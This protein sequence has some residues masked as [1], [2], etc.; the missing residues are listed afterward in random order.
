MIWR[1]AHAD[2]P[3]AQQLLFEVDWDRI[4]TDDVDSSWLNWQSKFL[5]IMEICIPKK[6]LSSKRRNLPWLTKRIVQAMRR[7]NALFKQ[8]MRNR[9]DS[10]YAKY[11]EAR[12]NVVSSL[13]SAK[14]GYFHKPSYSKKFW[15]AVKCLN[16]NCS[17]IPTLTHNNVSYE[18]DED[19]A[20]VLNLHFISCFNNTVE[21]LQV[22][23]EE[24][25]GSVQHYVQ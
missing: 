21:P 6:V 20:A 7:R 2:F 19:K 10:D 9:A 25:C 22:P 12:N 11:H 15:Q 18:S 1:Y 8:A 23:D 4:I 24:T 17:S 5:E 3:L 14:S 16:K 13:R